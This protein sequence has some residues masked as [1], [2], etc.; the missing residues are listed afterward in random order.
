MQRRETGYYSAI[1]PDR[2]VRGE[3]IAGSLSAPVDRR[4]M[5]SMDITAI[6][7]ERRN[8][9]R[10]IERLESEI[11]MSAASRPDRSDVRRRLSPAFDRSAGRGLLLQPDNNDVYT[12]LPRSR[13]VTD[14]TRGRRL[15][16]G[17]VNGVGN[18]GHGSPQQ[19]D[20]TGPDLTGPHLTGPDRTSPVLTGPTTWSVGPD[21]MGSVQPDRTGPDRSCAWSL[22]VIS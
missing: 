3:T 10:D 9:E 2:T 15:V 13:Y 4:R 18:N 21:R 16:G 5:E 12:L 22:I 7:T 11:A 1:G 17:V 20:L 6:L 8:L 19:P 14:R